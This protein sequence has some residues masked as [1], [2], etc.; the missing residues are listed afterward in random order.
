MKKYFLT[1]LVAIVIGF[2]LSNFFIKQYND[3]EGIKVSGIGE[4]IYF[5][6]F[7]VFSTKENMEENTISLQNY[8]YN[9]EDNL[10]Y[11]YVGITKEEENAKK[12]MDYYK[13]LGYDTLL[14]KFL[15][16]NEDF[17]KQLNNYEEVLSSTDDET[18]IASVMNQVL[19]KYEE[20][21]INGSEDKGHTD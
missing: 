19:V 9:E 13:K 3:F 20:V 8:V 14:K 6:Q 12:I 7:G 17:L 15:V 11:V 2:F 4:E 16:S 10:F 18:A 5:I 1:F 21:V